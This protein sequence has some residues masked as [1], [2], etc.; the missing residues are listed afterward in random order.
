MNRPDP[1]PAGVPRVRSAGPQGTQLLSVQELREYAEAVPS[2]DER[3]ST[4]QPVLEG[5][6]QGIE[7]RR[8]VLRSGRQTIGRRSDSNIILDDLSVSASHAWII[9]Q[10]GH[11]VV[12]NTLSTNGTFVNEQ[13][14]HEAVL[15]HGDRLRLGQVEFVFLTREPDEGSAARLALRIVA[16]I[17]M[18]AA[19]AAAAWWL[20]R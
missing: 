14:I 16:G 8:F 11:Y 17:V 9:N 18:V 3:A 19:V 4:H 6:S 10:H 7:G 15:K 13:R 20:V 5:V 1:L 12:M 2:F